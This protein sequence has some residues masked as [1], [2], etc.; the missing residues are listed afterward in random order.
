MKK[1]VLFI[2]FFL[3]F[4][5]LYA[6]TI[7]V[8]HLKNG[9]DA[10]GTITNRS[11]NH[12]TLQ[13]ENGRTL[14]IDMSEIESMEQ[15]QKKFDPKVLIGRWACYKSNGER[16]PRYDMEIRENEGF[17]T[18]SYKSTLRYV[19]YDNNLLGFPSQTPS[20]TENDDKD[21]EVE[22]GKV[23]YYFYQVEWCKMN[24]DSKRRQSINLLKYAS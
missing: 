11:E 6:Q 21:I 14:T 7:D 12:I 17:Y 2:A 15:E 4:S 18:V 23:S 1:F 22:D 19:S 3:S 24:A 8:I 5:A 16:D 9:F 13:S 10:K 20:Y